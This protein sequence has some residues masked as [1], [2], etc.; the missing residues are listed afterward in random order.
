VVDEWLP[1]F[2]ILGNAI[3]RA[4]LMAAVGF[5][6]GVGLMVFLSFISG[7]WAIPCIFTLA[8]AFS[9]FVGLVADPDKDWDFGSFP[10]FGGSGP[11]TPINL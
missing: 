5:F 10:T 8:I 4:L 7:N 11:R 6:L 3:L 2:D 9:A 1:D